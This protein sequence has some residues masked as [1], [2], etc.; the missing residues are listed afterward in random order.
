MLEQNGF[1][2][3]VIEG[4]ERFLLDYNKNKLGKGGKRQGLG[5]LVRE[6]FFSFNA[7]NMSK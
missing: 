6:S 4:E 2:R 7:E 1:Q 5:Y 3:S